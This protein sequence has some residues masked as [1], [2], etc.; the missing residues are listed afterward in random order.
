[1]G[2]NTDSFYIFLWFDDI[3]DGPLGNFIYG[4]NDGDWGNEKTCLFWRAGPDK[5]MDQLP[6]GAFVKMISIFF[7]F[8][9]HSYIALCIKTHINNFNFNYG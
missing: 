9:K 6:F 4:F 1:M 8:W 3:I 5:Q 7:V 2:G